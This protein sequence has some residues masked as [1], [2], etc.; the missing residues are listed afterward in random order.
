MN[1]LKHLNNPST[2]KI[3]RK[4]SYEDEEWMLNNAQAKN[5]KTKCHKKK[6]NF[7]LL[8]S[9]GNKLF[10]V[11]T[12]S[13][14]MSSLTRYPLRS[15]LQMGSNLAAIKLVAELQKLLKIHKLEPGELKRNLEF[16]HPPCTYT[17]THTYI[18]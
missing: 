17:H 10:G 5:F 13:S 15:S 6:I 16:I 12:D 3:V 2:E 8:P 7:L 14:K 11:E 4:N 1:K 9:Q 18:S